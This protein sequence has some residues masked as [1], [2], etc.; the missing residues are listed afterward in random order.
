MQRVR[1]TGKNG[2]DTGDSADPSP[3]SISL[4]LTVWEQLL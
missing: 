2:E 1:Y 4:Q 3:G